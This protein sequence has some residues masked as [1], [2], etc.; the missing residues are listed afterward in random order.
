MKKSII[1]ILLAVFAVS[2]MATTIHEIQYTEDPS[3]DSPYADQ[4]VNDVEGIVMATVFHK[5]PA[6]NIVISTP[7]GGEWSGLYVYSCGDST[8]VIGDKVRVSGL[9]VEYYG[10]T[11]IT[12]WVNQAVEPSFS[13]EKLSSGNDLPA[14]TVASADDMK[15]EAYES[16]FMRIENVVVAEDGEPTEETHYEWYVEDQEGG[17]Q[18]IDDNFFYLDSV[19][20]PIEI[21]EGDEFAAIQGIL[22]YSWDIYGLSPRVPEDI[23][24]E[25]SNDDDIYAPVANAELHDNYPNPFNPTTNLKFSL[26]EAANV[27]LTIYNVKGE[28]VKTVANGDFASGSHSIEWNGKDNNNKNVSSGVYYFKMRSG[29]FTRSKKMI[30]LK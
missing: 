12:G 4:V 18:Q 8:L 16:C 10:Q 17:E 3:G 14:P 5:G 25:V 23:I 1:S 21:H 27:E 24:A 26:K 11:Q 13:I 15:S 7:E 20:P 22:D 30:L 6:K 9:V 2:A 28:K 19:E 29:R